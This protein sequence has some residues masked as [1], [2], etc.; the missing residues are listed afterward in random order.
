MEDWQQG[1]EDLSGKADKAGRGLP[2]GKDSGKRLPQD[3]GTQRNLGRQQQQQGEAPHQKAR[4]RRGAQPA[5]PRN[6]A[7]ERPAGAKHQRKLEQ[8]GRCLPQARGKRQNPHGAEQGPEQEGAGEIEEGGGSGP[9]HS[10]PAAR[11]HETVCRRPA[12]SGV[13]G[14]HSPSARNGRLSVVQSGC[15]R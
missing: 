8:N 4:A 7:G 5:A 11:Y 6:P 12:S 1:E 2:V 13:A 3:E 14:A 10:S 9:P 15:A